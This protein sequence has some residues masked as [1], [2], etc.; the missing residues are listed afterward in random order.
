MLGSR[1][2]NHWAN[3]RLR[4]TL[5]VYLLHAIVDGSAADVTSFNKIQAFYCLSVYCKLAA[6]TDA[7]LV[8]LS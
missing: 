7:T 1:Y 2:D 3:F 6:G 4:L 8:L 5:I